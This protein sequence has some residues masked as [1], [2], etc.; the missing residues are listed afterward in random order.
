MCLCCT[1]TSCS[2]ASFHSKFCMHFKYHTTLTAEKCLLEELCCV[3]QVPQRT[4]DTA[5]KNKKQNVK[6]PKL[7]LGTHYFLLQEWADS[8]TLTHLMWLKIL[9]RLDAQSHPPPLCHCSV[10]YTS[11]QLTLDSRLM[12]YAFSSRSSCQF[13]L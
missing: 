6:P 7:Q 2:G 1:H 8:S 9:L 13:K 12:E 3:F 5:V 4:F 10:S 11:T